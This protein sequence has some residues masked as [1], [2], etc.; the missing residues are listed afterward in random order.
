MPVNNSVC[1]SW[2]QSAVGN[3]L[4]LAPISFIPQMPVAASVARSSKAPQ[5]QA[6]FLLFI[7]ETPISGF[8]VGT[9]G[10][11]SS[12]SGQ[13][14]FQ[15][16]AEYSGRVF[17]LAGLHTWGTGHNKLTKQAK[18]FI[19]TPTSEHPDITATTAKR[20]HLF[21]LLSMTSRLQTK[22]I[23]LQ[24]YLLIYYILISSNYILTT[25]A[26]EAEYSHELKI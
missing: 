1:Y 10:W 4:K 16:T 26:I 18:L 5:L 25:S 15:S 8:R 12:L 3:V 6:A 19:L 9:S 20:S 14:I 17:P 22:K 7:G 11:S 21:F 2:R 13:F 24:H 23:Q